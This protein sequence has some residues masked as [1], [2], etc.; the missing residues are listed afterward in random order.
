M[1]EKHR[2]A[3]SVFLKTP[4]HLQPLFLTVCLKRF[5]LKAVCQL[6]TVSWDDRAVN[7]QTGVMTPRTRLL[8]TAGLLP[9]GR[10]I[11]IVIRVCRATKF[12]REKTNK[13]K[14]NSNLI[15]KSNKVCLIYLL[16][17]TWGSVAQGQ[18]C[19]NCECKWVQR[20]GQLWLKRTSWTLQRGL[21]IEQ[22]LSSGR[23]IDPPRFWLISGL[24]G[25]N[26][27]NYGHCC[28]ESNR[29]ADS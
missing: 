13:N 22:S 3:L 20:G 25:E 17:F 26:S 21:L 29:H 27:A 6:P 1:S 11:T 5:F 2:G 7:F 4:H 14:L 16:Q 18:S 12:F 15:E 10:N 9:K 19:S 23:I 28:S 8:P 24:G